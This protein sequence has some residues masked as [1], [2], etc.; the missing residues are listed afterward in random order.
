VERHQVRQRR[1]LTAYV[2]PA[3]D[4]H[5][6]IVRLCLCLARAQG[7]TASAHPQ[8]DQEEVNAG[9]GDQMAWTPSTRGKDV[10]RRV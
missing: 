8:E 6:R 1:S 10:R 5:G 4:V 2:V 9:A 7:R 3:A